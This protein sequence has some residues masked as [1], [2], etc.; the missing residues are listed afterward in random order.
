MERCR[1]TKWTTAGFL[2][3][4]QKNITRRFIS[5]SDEFTITELSSSGIP[6]YEMGYVR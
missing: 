1:H 2:L 3:K 4:R 6:A 5:Q